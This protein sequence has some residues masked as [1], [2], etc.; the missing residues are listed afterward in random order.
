H[1][2]VIPDP[3]ELR[4]QNGIPCGIQTV[5]EGRDG[6]VMGKG[7]QQHGCRQQQEP[8]LNVRCERTGHA[9]LRKVPVT[10]GS[11]PGI[12]R[13]QRYGL[14]RRSALLCA[15][16]SAASCVF[17]PVSAAWRASSSILRTLAVSKV[18]SSAVA[19]LS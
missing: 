11:S 15:S 4:W 12:S 6:R 19:Y 3:H 17:L 10:S 9:G 1:L 8:S 16:V 13:D 18:A 2:V 5:D 14:S 7:N